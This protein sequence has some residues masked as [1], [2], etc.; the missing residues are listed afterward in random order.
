[1]RLPGV[2]VCSLL[3]ASLI[4]AAASAQSPDATRGVEQLRQRMNPSITQKPP[5][6]GQAPAVEAPSASGWSKLR[7]GFDEAKVTALLG[8]PDRVERQPQAARWHWER[9][10]EQGWV[11][12]AGEPLTVREWRS[13]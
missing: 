5:A 13:R 4:A 12:F 3:T 10:A 2:H 1:M 9:G 7:V 8:A 11:E 6:T